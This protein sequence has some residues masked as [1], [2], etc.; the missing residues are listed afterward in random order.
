MRDDWFGIEKVLEKKLPRSTTTRSMRAASS[1]LRCKA[2][3]S[4]TM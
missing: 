2:K 4:P 3:T 1:L